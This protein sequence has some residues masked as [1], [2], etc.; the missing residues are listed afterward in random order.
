MIKL[1]FTIIVISSVCSIRAADSKVAQDPYLPRPTVEIHQLYQPDKTTLA[2][3][4]LSALLPNQKYISVSCLSDPK[5]DQNP[6]SGTYT[7]HDGICLY[8][9]ED[10]QAEEYYNILKTIAQQA[11]RQAVIQKQVI[12]QGK[13]K[14][15]PI[16]SGR[17]LRPRTRYKFR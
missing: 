12:K 7:I 10:H 5:P 1:F 3:E 4:T 17:I 16:S 11:S 14:K 8:K 2:K 13:R 6:Y 9:L 15:G